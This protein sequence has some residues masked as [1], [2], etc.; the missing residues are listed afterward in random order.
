MVRQ[1]FSFP[2]RRRSSRSRSSALIW[3]GA[4]TGLVAYLALAILD[5]RTGTLRGS[6]TQSTVVWFLVAFAGFVMALVAAELRGISRRWLWAVPIIF[7]LIMLTTQPTLSDDVYRY[8]WDGHL[9]TEGVSPYRYPISA[10]ELDPYEIPARR[11]ANNTD[12]ASP[13][14]PTAHAV[15]TATSVLLPQRPLSLQLVMTAFDI[16]AAV[17]LMR[18]LALAGLPGHRV[19]LYLWEPAGN[20]RGGA[21]CPP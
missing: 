6:S 13:Y 18:L 9:V 8:I 2:D 3:V 5:N 11:L 15:F 14:L 4:G 21:R 12:L 1:L 10:P 20:H 16:G 17:V 7:R 19:M